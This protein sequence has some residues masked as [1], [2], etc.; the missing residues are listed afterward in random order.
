MLPPHELK[1]VHVT[2]HISQMRWVIGKRLESG[3]NVRA[4]VCW[5]G[6]KSIIT[7]DLEVVWHGL[8]LIG[9]WNAKASGDDASLEWLL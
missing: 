8:I 3:M 5:R 7:R 6:C 1:L 4:K 2:R 9:E